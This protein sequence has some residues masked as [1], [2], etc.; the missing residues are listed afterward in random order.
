MVFK[1]G[2]AIEHPAK[3]L[4]KLTQITLPDQVLGS[5]QHFK[6]YDPLR[7]RHFELI[8]GTVHLYMN[9][10]DRLQAMQEY[11]STVEAFRYE[12]ER[13]VR[14]ETQSYKSFDYTD[15]FQSF[16]FV[17]SKEL[18]ANDVTAMMIE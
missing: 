3:D 12:V 16:T 17:I 7:I 10:L 11:R 1:G 6:N 8:N 14:P 4:S 18:F 2:V 13:R 9:E 15:N 5:V